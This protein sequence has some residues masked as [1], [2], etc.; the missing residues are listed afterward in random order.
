M[1]LLEAAIESLITE[2]PSHCSGHGGFDEGLLAI[3]SVNSKKRKFNPLLNLQ[4][5]RRL[6][7]RLRFRITWPYQ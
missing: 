5:L 1:P 7:K 3:S 2:E 4:G 6:R